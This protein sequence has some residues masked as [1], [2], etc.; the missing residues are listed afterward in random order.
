MRTYGQELSRDMSIEHTLIQM[1]EGHPGCARVLIELFTHASDP[2]R[3]VFTLDDMNMRGDRIWTAFH[4]LCGDN[5]E[6]FI[7]H[8]VARDAQ[9][10]RT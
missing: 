3:I 4:E 8:V 5:I 6:M 2:M 1:T 7:S 9:I 10:V